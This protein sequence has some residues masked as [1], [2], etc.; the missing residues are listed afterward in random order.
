MSIKEQLKDLEDKIARGGYI[1]NILLISFFVLIIQSCWHPETGLSSFEDLRENIIVIDSIKINSTDSIFWYCI[2]LGVQGYSSGKIGIANNRFSLEKEHKPLLVS[3][4]ITGVKVL[5]RD[6]LQVK[7]LPSSNLAGYVPDD[8]HFKY[9][10][11]T[12][13]G[14]YKDLK[15]YR[16]EH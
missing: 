9:I 14:G 5:S 4:D 13:T 15:I 11:I 10:K 6:T 12:K 1:K 3:D 16:I 2:D 8:K 7:V